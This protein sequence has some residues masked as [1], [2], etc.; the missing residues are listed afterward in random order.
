MREKVAGIFG[1]LVELSQYKVAKKADGFAFKN[2]VNNLSDT[3]YFSLNDKTALMGYS[4]QL[5]LFSLLFR[6]QLHL[7][8]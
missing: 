3:L 4:Y 2:I 8:R 7:L 1:T 5:K 6:L